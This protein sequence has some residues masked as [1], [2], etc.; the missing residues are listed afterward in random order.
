MG[1][2]LNSSLSSLIAI[3][4]LVGH[5]LT[6]P[7][8]FLNIGCIAEISKSRSIVLCKRL[9]LSRLPLFILTFFS[10]IN[11]IGLPPILTFLSEAS[12]FGLIYMSGA[13]LIGTIICLGGLIVSGFY[14]MYLMYVCCYGVIKLTILPSV[15]ELRIIFIF[16]LTSIVILVLALSKK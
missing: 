15:K 9:S 8:L 4:I 5:G 7:A 3:F 16:C 13:S 2:S 14:S 10:V 12:F 1:L 6:S 11:N